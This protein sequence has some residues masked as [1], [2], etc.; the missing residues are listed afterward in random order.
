M[1]V[2]CAIIV[3]SIYAYNLY[4]RGKTRAKAEAKG[5]AFMAVFF[6]YPTICIVSF[7]AFICRQMGPDDSVLESDDRVMC[8]DVSHRAV[9]GVSWGVV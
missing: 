5:H 6:C 1:P 2:V 8:E 7:A 3:L 4:K 9:Q